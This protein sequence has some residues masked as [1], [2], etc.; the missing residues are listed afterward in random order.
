MLSRYFSFFLSS[1]FPCSFC[2]FLQGL[3]GVYEY[4]SVFGCMPV[5]FYMQSITWH[6]LL[7]NLLHS[8]FMGWGEQ[9]AIR[10]HVLE[11]VSTEIFF[12]EWSLWMWRRI[13]QLGII[14]GEGFCVGGNLSLLLYPREPWAEA[15]NLGG[16]DTSLAGIRSTFQAGLLELDALFLSSPG[17]YC[18]VKSLVMGVG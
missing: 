3:D 14:K 5:P 9:S 13:L 12:D 2:I 15:L 16:Q 18:G 10:E 7:W 4:V 6:W 1:A 8:C 17:Q 11:L